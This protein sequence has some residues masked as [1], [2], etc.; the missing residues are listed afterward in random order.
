MI[1]IRL[2][3][4]LWH[5]YITGT[6]L[7][8][9]CVCM[10]AF[11]HCSSEREKAL[12]TSGCWKNVVVVL[13]NGWDRAGTLD[14]KMT[15]FKQNHL[16]TREMIIRLCYIYRAIYYGLHCDVIQVTVISLGWKTKILLVLCLSQNH[17][18]QLE[19]LS[20]NERFKNFNKTNLWC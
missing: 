1:V 3:P 10:H 5:F 19:Y 4:L 9:I 16:A 18:S 8:T 13:N 12:L 20:I 2:V 7:I 14:E 11:C 17:Q 15:C 6:N